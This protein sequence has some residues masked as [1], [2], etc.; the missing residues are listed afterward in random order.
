[1]LQEKE[2]YPSHTVMVG[3]T[4]AHDM[5]GAHNLHID[6]CLVK[7]GLH[8]ANFAHCQNPRETWAALKNL[9]AVFNNV[10]PIYLK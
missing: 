2:V 10:M 3:D 8:A 4:M 9:I 6:T 5:I 7:S 1:L